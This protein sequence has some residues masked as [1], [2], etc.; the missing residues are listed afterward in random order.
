MR[1]L[2]VR[3]LYKSAVVL[4]IAGVPLWLYI[5]Q[6]LADFTSYHH[7]PKKKHLTIVSES[8]V[9]LALW[10]HS[11]ADTAVSSDQSA[12]TLSYF[13]TRGVSI[14]VSD[15]VLSA[16]SF[17]PFNITWI[18]LWKCPRSDVRTHYRNC[19]SFSAKHRPSTR[20]PQTLLPA[21]YVI[22]ILM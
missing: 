4:A 12:F 8:W 11:P 7:P 20:L 5:E 21:Q 22:A 19:H 14:T 9:I 3:Q 16:N 10:P 17:L 1:L 18:K 13:N 6:I 15:H 2:W